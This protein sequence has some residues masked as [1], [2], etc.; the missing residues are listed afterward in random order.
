MST[1]EGFLVAVAA[2][3]HS[4]YRFN[5]LAY[6]PQNWLK[7]GSMLTGFE[8]H[9]QGLHAFLACAACE[10]PLNPDFP[11]GNLRSG[12]LAWRFDRRSPEIFERFKR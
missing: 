8:L 9:H 7:M 6:E 4:C 1:S 12:M 2:P 11:N 10:G 3:R 5:G